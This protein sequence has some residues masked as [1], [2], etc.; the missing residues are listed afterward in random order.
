M[1]TLSKLSIRAVLGLILTVLGVL[2]VALSGGALVQAIG[3]AR[4]AD[5]V[6]TR[7]PIAETLFAIL[8]D[9]RHE[10][11]DS[12]VALSAET[13]IDPARGAEIVRNGE[14]SETSYK[15]SLERLE[16]LD[17]PGLPALVARLRETHAPVETLRPRA[18]AALRQAMAAR[19]PGLTKSWAAATQT[20]MDAVEAIEDRVETSLELVDPE[21]DQLLAI[22]RASWT[23]RKSAG[24]VTLRISS[25]ISAG[26]GWSPAETLANAEE[27]GRVLAAWAIV[28]RAVER[29]GIPPA[30]ADAIG[31]GNGYFG[32]APAAERAAAEQALADGRKPDITVEDFLKHQLAMLNEVHEAVSAALDAVGARADAQRGAALR[33]LMLNGGMLLVAVALTAAGFAIAQRR[34]SRP[35]RALTASMGRLADHDV[36]AEIPGSGRGD[37]IGAMARAVAVFKDSMIEADRLAAEQRAEQTRK[38]Q[39]QHA[40]EGHIRAFDESVSSSLRSLA[41]ASSELQA[42][43]RSMSETAEATNRQ[44]T[45]VAAASEQATINVQ[46]VAS[47]AEELSSSIAEIGRQVSESTRISGEAVEQAERTNALVQTLADGAQRI[48]D[49][50]KLINDIAGQTNL[51]ALNATIEAARAGEAGKGFA[52]VASEVKNLATQTARATGDITAQIDAI[53]SATGGAVEAI[54]AIGDTIGKVNAIAVAIASAVEQ[55]GAATREIARNVQQASAG[56]ADVSA[57]IAGVTQSVS[58]TGAAAAQVLGSAGTLASLSDALRREIDGFVHQMRAA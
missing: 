43:S 38:E 37:E 47:A 16:R 48:G 11:S 7:A 23:V 54:Q 57:N 39:R 56:T 33:S 45:A 27:R 36:A 41:T 25:A 19:E 13:A 3:H 20:Y 15:T 18:M 24:G 8:R 22:K 58:L 42:T 44:S 52:V 29:P 32:G 50:V 1:Q 6:A 34:I 55:Q 40:I 35:I 12:L 21:I 5:Q 31:R 30:L 46:T 14:A 4:I 53:Q 10:R 51:L 9:A 17:L 26:R 2:L 28:M 49:V